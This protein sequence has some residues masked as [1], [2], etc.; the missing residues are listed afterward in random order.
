MKVNYEKKFYKD[1]D[2]IAKK[3]AN[4]KGETTLIWERWTT[5]SKAKLVACTGKQ[6]SRRD[7]LL[8]CEDIDRQLLPIVRR[9]WLQVHQ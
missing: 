2:G 1:D 5:P 6:M 8:A 9:N 7:Q 3:V 4:E